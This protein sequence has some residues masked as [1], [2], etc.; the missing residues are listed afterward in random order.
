MRS[1]EYA[2][3]LLD[4]PEPTP[5]QIKEILAL[6]KNAMAG[7]GDHFIRAGKAAPSH[8]GDGRPQKIKDPLVRASIREEI[9]RRHEPGV[10]LIPIFK[11]LAKHHKVSWPNIRR[12]WYEG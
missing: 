1:N 8:K 11:D 9:K 5:D 6:L 12:I 7:L 10:Q 4:Q 2:D 3:W